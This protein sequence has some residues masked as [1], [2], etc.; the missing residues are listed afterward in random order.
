MRGD[1]IVETSSC[2]CKSKRKML[3]P[4]T[5]GETFGL[6]TVT[7]DLGMRVEKERNKRCVEVKCKCG[8]KPKV[9]EW[10]VLKRGL[11]KSCGCTRNTKKVG[12]KHG[13]VTIIS[14]E[15]TSQLDNKRYANV[16]CVCGKEFPIAF[17]KITKATSCGCKGKNGT[18]K[19]ISI[20]KTFGNLTVTKDLG[21]RLV[22]GYTR[23][24]V[25]VKCK[26]GSKPKEV[27]MT[28]LLRGITKSCGCLTNRKNPQKANPITVTIGDTYGQF[29]LTKDL[30]TRGKARTRYV[31]VTCSC[32][33][34]REARWY[35]V[36]NKLPLPCK[37]CQEKQKLSG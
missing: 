8:S 9:V 13:F 17:S 35:I 29:T 5:I 14:D 1:K 37:G 24:Y 6:L 30:G 3:T 11:T 18:Q 16:Q 20:G 32:G 12:E 34:P 27:L 2:G 25:E 23:H 4:I 26:C 10:G 22:K 21:C 7:K 15:G 36:K 33:T 19:T 31:E 28:N